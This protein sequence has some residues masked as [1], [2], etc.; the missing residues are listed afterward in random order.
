[1][2]MDPVAFRMFVLSITGLIAI[3]Y[4]SLTF[5]RKS[6][7]VDELKRE[8]ERAIVKYRDLCD[9]LRE[10]AEKVEILKKI[11]IDLC[12]NPKLI[13]LTIDHSNGRDYLTKNFNLAFTEF[14]H[15]EAER[16]KLL[17]II[18]RKPKKII[19]APP[20]IEVDQ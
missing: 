1:M 9:E 15:E 17:S 18:K 6:K 19:P 14:C 2:E 12:S 3:T 5:W 16:V 8:F 13:I 4:V 7:K 10:T 20:C 11:Q